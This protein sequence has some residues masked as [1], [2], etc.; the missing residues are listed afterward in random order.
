LFLLF[1]QDIG[2]AH[3]AYKPP[4]ASMSQTLLSSAGFQVILIGRFW[5]ITEDEVPQPEKCNLLIIGKIDV[6]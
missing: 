6:Y 5:V 3:G 1:V 4:L 2:H